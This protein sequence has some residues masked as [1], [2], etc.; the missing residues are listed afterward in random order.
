M[1]R[2]QRIT[3]TIILLLLIT[4]SAIWLKFRNPY[5]TEYFTP[6]MQTKYSTVE[7]VLA[8]M[9]EGWKYDTDAHAQLMNEAYG[10][11]VAKKYGKGTPSS[12]S[13]EEVKSISYSKDNKM[14]YALSDRSDH[15]FIRHH[16]RWV[17]YPETPWIMV[18]ELMHRMK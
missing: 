1:K 16:G 15:Y 8:A 9:K 3:A 11:D 4:A 10:F 13:M 5:A 18:L 6:E 2:A 7:S 12:E 17:F 14:A